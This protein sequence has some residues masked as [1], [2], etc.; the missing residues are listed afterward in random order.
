[1]SLAKITLI[2]MYNYDNTLFDQLSV[3]AGLDKN[4]LINTLL[5]RGGEFEVLYANFDFMKAAIGVWSAKWQRTME[6]WLRVLSM[7]YDPI[8]NYDRKEDWID[9]THNKRQENATGTDVSVSEGDGVTMNGR[10]TYDSTDIQP[11]D[12]SRSTTSGSNNSASN[13]SAFGETNT[14]GAH[15]GRIHGNIG[16]KTTQSMLLEEMDVDKLNVYE[17]IAELFLTELVIYVY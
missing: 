12:Q 6:K 10:S 16:V 5:L 15:T 7:E 2:G 17:E 13:T 14:N 8:E 1:M 4:L 11:H 3:P 9:T